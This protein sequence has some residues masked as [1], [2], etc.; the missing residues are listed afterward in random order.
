MR[1]YNIKQLKGHKNENQLNVIILNLSSSLVQRPEFLVR[2]PEVS[3]SI[4][5]AT[6][7]SET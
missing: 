1:K 7:Y 5:G 6:R 4:P 3:G 2:Y